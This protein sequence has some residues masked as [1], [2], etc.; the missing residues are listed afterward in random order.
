MLGIR[1][2]P[3]R[4]DAPRQGPNVSYPPPSASAL[5]S[6]Q[7]AWRVW[8][9]ALVSVGMAASCTLHG[10]GHGAER[11]ATERAATNA[12][13]A[14]QAYVGTWRYV[15]TCG[16]QHSADLQ[17][18]T[19]ADG[20]R[21]HWSDGHRAGGQSGELRGESREGKVFLRFCR[22]DI[23]PGQADACPRFGAEAGYVVREGEALAWYRS[24]GAAGDQPYL[25]LHRVVEGRDVPVDD[26]CPDQD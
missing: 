13:P 23:A 16:W 25:R 12:A 6:P 26:R 24:S 7:R 22:D 9:L 8:R 10:G 11:A 5:V 19:V 18:D 1:P 15:Q 20:I 2:G 17:F 21:G 14:A 3:P 4:A